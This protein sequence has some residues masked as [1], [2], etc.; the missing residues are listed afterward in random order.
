MQRT[1]DTGV[2]PLK[3]GGQVYSDPKE[4]ASILADQFKSVFTVDSDENRDNTIEGPTVP[5]LPDLEITLKGVKL[6]LRGIDPKKA[7]GP[8]EVPCRILCT[9]SDELAPAFTMLFQRSYE[10]AVMPDVWSTAWITPVFKKGAK[11]DAANFRAFQ[12]SDM[13]S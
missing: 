5:P 10:H 2:A 3:R 13:V 9:L 12:N 1:E 7:A 11:F 8:D 4:Q 6:L